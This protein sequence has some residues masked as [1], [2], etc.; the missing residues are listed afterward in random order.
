M[1]TIASVEQTALFN[2]G[3]KSRIKNIGFILFPETKSRE[4]LRFEGNKIH[5]LSRD[6]LLSD[7]LYRKTKQKQ[8]L[9]NALRFL[10]QH[11]A[12]VNCTL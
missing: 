5:C 3:L 11:Q 10:R 2:F 9:K 6:Q 12:T 8:I 7:L 4:T 1:K